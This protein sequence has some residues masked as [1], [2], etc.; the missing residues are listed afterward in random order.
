[1]ARTESTATV[2]R[3]LRREVPCTVG[4]LADEEDFTAMRRYR[5][6]TFDD[7][8]TYLH[9]VEDLLKRL[10]SQGGHT[11]VALFDP[12]DYAD[13]CAR[14]GLDPDDPASRS[15][16]TAEVAAT[17]A[18]VTYSGQPMER[19]VPLLINQAVR[20]ATWEYAALLLAGDG[21]CTRCGQDTART[22]LDRAAGLLHR[23][24]QAA[25]AGTHHLVCSVPAQHEHLMAVLHAERTGTG[26]AELDPSEG[27]EFATVLAAG[28]A[29]ESPGGLVLRT[30]T[31]G[32]PDRVHG[33]RL[34]RGRIIPLSAAEVFDAYCTDADTGEPVA[35]EHNVD[36]LAGFD[37]TGDDD[38][39]A[40]H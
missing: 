20:H 31:P 35:P 18:R 9:Q 10:A 28:L 15:R 32:A 17:G 26:P 37:I 40:H 23:L 34:D 29:L 38:P 5:T 21:A 24:L 7:H 14:A 2:R 25:G 12:E 1:M 11:S 27:A 30:T 19:L 39:P 36:Y 22:A 16:F 8:S 6:F 3:A 4:L 13:Y 33:W